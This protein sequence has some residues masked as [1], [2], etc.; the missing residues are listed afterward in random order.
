MTHLEA[1]LHTLRA[2]RLRSIFA[3]F[4][5]FALALATC[6][7]PAGT[8]TVTGPYVYVA[9]F[10]SSGADGLSAFSIGSGGALS[11]ITSGTLTTGNQPAAIAISP[12]GKYLFV[13]NNGT[14]GANGLSAFS[15][16]SGG[17]LAASASYTT[18]SAPDAIAISPD[19][20]Y[21]YVANGNSTGADGLSAFSIGSGGALSASGPTLRDRARAPSPSAPTEKTST[22]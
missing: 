10:G 3:A 16:G 14:L 18:G 9:N 21:L 4:I 11:A 20:K 1:L 12:D 15:I 5:P 2:L 7:N 17:A 6:A 8:T 13:A 19:G 22:S